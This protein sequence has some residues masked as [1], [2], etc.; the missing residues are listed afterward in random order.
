MII[1]IADDIT[2]AAEMAGIALKHGLDTILTTETSIPETEP[3]VLVIAT[4]TRSG[5][6]SDAGKLMK[7]LTAIIPNGGNNLIFKKTDSVLRG[8]ITTELDTIMATKDFDEALL[9][10]QNPSKGRVIKNGTYYI[11]NIPLDKTDFNK[12]PEFPAHS[13]SVKELLKGKVETLDIN[14]PLK[15]NKKIF[16]ADAENREEI[17]LQLGKTSEKTLLAGGADLFTALL[18]NKYR[19]EISCTDISEMAVPESAIIICGSTQSKNI[20][21][22]PYIK[23]IG[24]RE[25]TMPYGVF[26][27]DAPDEWFDQLSATYKESKSI[28]VSVGKKENGGKDCAIRLRSIMAE[29]TKQLVAAEQPGLMIIEGGATA[30]AILSN[31]GWKY[32][33]LKRE[34]AP[35][36]VSMTYGKTEIILKP[37]SYPWGNLFK[38][39]DCI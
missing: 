31:I 20:T 33:K 22:E 30:Y 14:E 8:H 23:R 13:S 12:D 35:G 5:S 21:C 1:V 4:D 17:I 27:G 28:I 34:Y 2:G 9:L 26:R 11:G 39:G 36:I 19:K 15:R 25:E 29:A 3:E 6:E 37:G 32:F 10:P 38:D 18:Q 24:A 16:I 7:H